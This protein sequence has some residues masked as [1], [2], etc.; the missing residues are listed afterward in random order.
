MVIMMNGAVTS[1]WETVREACEDALSVDE[2][3]GA[4]AIVHRGQTVVDVWGGTDPL[5]GLPWRQDSITLGFSTAKGVVALLVAQE[6]EA[7]RL[8]PN[9]PVATYWPEFAQNGK[10]DI[11]LLQVLTHTAGMPVLSMQ[12]VDDLLAPIELAQRLAG[13]PP[14][15]PP[16]T[17]RIYHVLSYGTILAEVLRRVTGK[18]VGTLVADRIA[19]PLAGS[20]WLGQPAEVESRYLPALMGPVEGPPPLGAGAGPACEAAFVANSQA[21]VIFER[22]DGVQGTEPM[23]QFA[24]RSAQLAAGGL[25]TDARSLARMYAACVGDVNGVRLLHPNTVDLVSSD[26]LRGIAEPPCY[27]SSVPTTRW[28]LGFEISHEHCPM[29]GE[30]SF[31]HAGM[32]GRLAFANAPAEL[33]FAFVSQRMMFPAPGEDVRWA[34]IL[35]AVRGVLDSI[36]VPTSRDEHLHEG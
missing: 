21:T 13:E 10:A 5:S 29:L 17:A 15:Y 23:N 2:A 4:L 7:G 18:D 6:I 30:G 14:S 28:G 16:A 12:S 1:G 33:G 3:G 11:T 31:G 26:Q 8:D 34:G 20:L 25:V 32:G 35:A 27:P 24:F 19:A 9:A 36:E 22:V